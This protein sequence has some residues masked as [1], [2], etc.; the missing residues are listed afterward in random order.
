MTT[1]FKFRGNTDLLTF[2]IK[3]FKMIITKNNFKRASTTR[4]KA[5]RV[6]RNGQQHA[7]TNYP[8][9]KE[10]SIDRETSRHRQGERFLDLI[11]DFSYFS[12]FL[13]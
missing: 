3:P 7:P 6:S 8:S 10:N 2:E 9:G 1:Y 11:F 5:E 13:N 12:T 4:Q